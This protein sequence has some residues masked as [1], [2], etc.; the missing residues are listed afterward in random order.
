MND[1]D[2]RILVAGSTGAVGAQV[3]R[4]LLAAGLSVRALGRNSEKLAGLAAAG[5]ETVAA[6]LLDRA[7]VV[8]ACEGIA[9]IYS[10][11]N[12]VMGHG[13]SSPN[14]VDVKAHEAL[15]DAA[16]TTGVRRIVYL[17]ARGMD[18]DG[19]VDFFRAKHAIEEVIR[20]SGVPWVMIRP[21]A[22]METWVGMIADG[23]RKNG[24][25]VLF[26]DGR[27]VGNYIAI[28]DVAEFSVRILQHN[29]ITNEAIDIGGPSSVAPDEL[30]SLIE[31]HL[32]VAARRRRI[33]V[34]VLWTAGLLLRPV[35]EVAARM[36][37][38]G[39]FAATRDGRFPEWVIAAERFG[40]TPISVETFV[41][42]LPH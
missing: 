38:M 13:T 17:S 20:R 21:G 19:P 5:A 33:P 3:V 22:F 30:V 8:R 35:N 39:Y 31:R 23:I 1:D 40:V 41:A 36:M 4:K 32:G 12:N 27:T 26:G 15:C 28:E 6:D 9:Q 2:S 11:A 18:G 34:S 16:R 14:R 10:T 7:A 24:T 42:G 37:R 25:A 29:D